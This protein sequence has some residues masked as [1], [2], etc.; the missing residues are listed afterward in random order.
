M[1]NMSA[2]LELKE[3]AYRLRD[4]A[5]MSVVITMPPIPKDAWDIVKYLAV[6]RSHYRN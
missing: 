4:A 2:V 5:A 6:R 1:D 3:Q